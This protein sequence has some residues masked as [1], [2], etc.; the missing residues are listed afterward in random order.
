MSNDVKGKSASDSDLI[1]I[2]P[3]V[4]IV[5]GIGLLATTMV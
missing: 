3:L 1:I 4:C 5:S 2:L